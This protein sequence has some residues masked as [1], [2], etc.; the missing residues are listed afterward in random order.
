MTRIV[1]AIPA[2]EALDEGYKRLFVSGGRARRAGTCRA[3]LGLEPNES[4]LHN[5][6]GKSERA[7]GMPE[8]A[9][10]LRLPRQRN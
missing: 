3:G 1:E 4:H 5:L 7:L 2:Y 9:G 6:K 10:S 8:E